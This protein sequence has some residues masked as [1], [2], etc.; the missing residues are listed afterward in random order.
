MPG[1]GTRT[2][3][4]PDHYEASLR[5]AQIE[6]V[7]TRGA[8]FKARQ[9]WAELHYLQ[10]LRCE[11]DLPRIG[12][13]TLPRHLACISFPGSSGPLPRWRGTELQPGDIMFHSLGERLHQTT[14]G[15]SVWS[16]ITLDPVQLDDYSRALFE[17]SI[18]PPAEGRMLRPCKPDAMRLRRLHAQACRLAE[19]KPKILAHPEVARAIEKDLIH[20]LVT[21]L[22]GAKVNEEGAA[23]RHHA[24]VMIRF[25]EVLTEHLAGLRHMPELCERV[26][27]SERTL[28]SSCVEFLAV[29][30]ARYVLLRR[31]KAV[32]KALRDGDPNSANVA[33]LAR[34]HGFT[35]PGR[36]AGMYRAAF[37]ENPSTTLQ[38]ASKP[39]FAAQQI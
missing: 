13:V 21:C 31:L 37:G 7:I 34:L 18:I 25:E 24:L 23:K 29:S 32:R 22:I 8:G 2:F 35:Q 11:E 10:L 36:F 9:I 14:F 15:A 17:K 16:L 3:L 38:R 5:Q 19:T 20:A 6:F 4:E 33:D 30:P 26:G 27:V 28:R 12:Y 39:R 1:G